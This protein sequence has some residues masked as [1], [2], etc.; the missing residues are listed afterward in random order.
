MVFFKGHL[1]LRHRLPQH[2]RPHHRLDALRLA[3]RV[4]AAPPEQH[5][6]VCREP[7]VVQHRVLVAHREVLG[8]QRCGLRFRQWLRRDDKRAGGENES[9]QLLL[10]K[11]MVLS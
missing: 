9:A 11:R 5:A 10:L 4:V 2:A 7:V 1:E 8:Q 6:S 3:A